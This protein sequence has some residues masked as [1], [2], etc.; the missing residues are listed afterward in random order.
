MKTILVTG[1]AGFDPPILSAIQ[2][3]LAKHLA[4]T[5]DFGMWMNRSRLLGG[6]FGSSGPAGLNILDR[7]TRDCWRKTEG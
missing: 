2:A 3:E 4:G 5:R 1:G 6:G 7:L